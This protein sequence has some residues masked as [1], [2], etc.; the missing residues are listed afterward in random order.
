MLGVAGVVQFM[1]VSTAERCRIVWT[2]VDSRPNY[3]PAL[4]ADPSMLMMARMM[5]MIPNLAF[6]RAPHSHDF[7]NIKLAKLGHILTIRAL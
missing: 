5:M 7:H 2:W 1:P 4:I 6:L 3:G